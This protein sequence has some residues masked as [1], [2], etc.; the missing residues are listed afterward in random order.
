MNRQGQSGRSRAYERHGIFSLCIELRKQT[1][2]KKVSFF[3]SKYKVVMSGVNRLLSTVARWAIPLSL[4]VAGKNLEYAFFVSNSRT[5]VNK[6]FICR[7][8]SRHVRWY[9]S[10]ECC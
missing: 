3:G 2:K 9:E 4:G 10:K 8:S 5:E 7:C 6:I 1:K